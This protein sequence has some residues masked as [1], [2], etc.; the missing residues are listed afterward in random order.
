MRGGSTA[1]LQLTERFTRESPEI[2]RYQVTV[3]DPATWT[4]PWTYE[5]PMQRNPAQVFEYACHE[6]NFSLA[7]ILIGARETEAAAAASH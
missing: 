5:V 6:G 2:L 3:N 1:A 4:R 7:T